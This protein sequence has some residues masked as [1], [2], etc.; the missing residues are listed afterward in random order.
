M[1]AD[2][3]ADGYDDPD[4]DDQQPTDLRGRLRSLRAAVERE[5]KQPGVLERIVYRGKTH[6][7]TGPPEAG[8]TVLALHLAVAAINAGVPV[9]YWDEEIG[10]PAAAGLLKAMGAEPERVDKYLAYMPFAGLAWTPRDRQGLRDLVGDIKP[11]LAI[12][13]SSMAMMG[14]AGVNENDNGQVTRFWQQVWQ[15]LAVNFGCCVVVIDHEGRDGAASRYARG[16]GSKLA[17]VDVAMKLTPVVPFTRAQDGL[18]QLTLTKDRPGWLNRHWHVKVRHSPLS[19][20]IERA[21]VG[22]ISP[23]AKRCLEVLTDVWMTP[24]DVGDRVADADP[25]GFGLKRETIS[26]AMRQLVQAGLV[27]D[28]EN[29]GRAFWRRSGLSIDELPLVDER[30]APEEQPGA[31]WPE[32]SE[33][34]AANGG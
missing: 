12:F 2:P 30:P 22:A 21:R 28:G 27:E 20:L 18:L 6:S 19:V 16:A 8:K 26:R 3:M 29:N 15:P 10:A 5:E 31:G 11:A 14:A 33:G 7:L 23:A 24:Q 17:V 32:G 13:D 9:L 34:A 25:G 4:S 1:S